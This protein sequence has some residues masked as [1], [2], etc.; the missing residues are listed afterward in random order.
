MM[1]QNNF[2]QIMSIESEQ[3]VLGI[4][5]HKP[6]II[7]LI[8]NQLDSGDFYSAHHRM[9]F[10]RLGTAF[11]KHGESLDVIIFETFFTPEEWNTCGGWAYMADLAQQAPSH[12]LASHHIERLKDLSYRRAMQASAMELIDS[13]ATGDIESINEAKQKISKQKSGYKRALFCL[14]SAIENMEFMAFNDA[15]KIEGVFN[16]CLPLGEPAILSAG[17]GTG[18]TFTIVQMIKSVATGLPVFSGDKPFMTPTKKGKCVII[19]AE[20]S[21]SDYHRRLQSVILDESLTEDQRRDIASNTIIKSLRGDDV[22]II[23]SDKTGIE[24][25]D[26]MERLAET[27]APWGE[28]RMI[29][30]DPMIRFY[31]AEE[32]NNSHAT[33]FINAA[34]KLSNLLCGNPAVMLVHHSSKDDA[35]GCRGASAFVD[36]ARTHLSMMTMEQ[37]KKKLGDKDIN[38]TD[39]NRIVLEMRKSNH[40]KYWDSYK[41]LERAENGTLKMANLED[42]RLLQREVDRI[43]ERDQKYLII[44][45]VQMSGG[46]S[47][48]QLENEARKTIVWGSQAPTRDK[49]KRI[50]DGLI[51]DGELVVMG[52]GVHRKLHVKQVNNNIASE[53]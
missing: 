31:D 37:K 9:I 49:M 13:L 36:G 22:R 38:P 4:A 50:V 5:L 7:P 52:E 11:A 41:V 53:F 25:T 43:Q 46:I 29:V 21:E 47:R 33:M 18:K 34:N 16:E 15:P 19:A 27:L 39:R 1:N 12:L 2:K 6:Q 44:Q 17:G 14:E 30:L 48:N 35:G 32:N 42:D 8:S 40:F 20:D 51:Q 28:I 3:C 45:A 26:F 10:S 24:I 23:K